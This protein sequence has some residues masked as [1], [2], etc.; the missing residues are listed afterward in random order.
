MLADRVLIERQT[1]APQGGP[2]ALE[3]LKARLR[4]LT[5]RPRSGRIEHIVEQLRAH[6][7]RWKA[8]FWPVVADTI[9]AKLRRWW[10]NRSRAAGHGAA[11][12]QIRP[13]RRSPPVVTSTPRTARCGPAVVPDPDS[14]R[15]AGK[16][17]QLPL[18][19]NRRVRRLRG[20]GS[21]EDHQLRGHGLHDLIQLVQRAGFG[22]NDAAIR[23]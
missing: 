13:P 23:L 12:S 4:Q 19:A 8:H 3:R 15:H 11:D 1:V 21:T 16:R 6:L 17:Q 22:M 5:R 18:D 9:A 7:P 2:K 20:S 10:R 14:G